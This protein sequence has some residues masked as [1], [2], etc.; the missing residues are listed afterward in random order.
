MSVTTA[1]APR[2]APP[3][4]LTPILLASLDAV[5]AAIAILAVVLALL[6]LGRAA[7]ASALR[8]PQTAASTPASV[9]ASP[10][11]AA[12]QAPAPPHAAPAVTYTVRAG[13]TLWSIS[14][15]H[16]GTGGD[17]PRLYIVNRVVIGSSPDHIEP[18]ETL[19]IPAISTGGTSP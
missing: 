3:P 5:V 12:A 2:H 7:P 1:Y 4:R 13:D 8:S 14:L 15:A 18:G 19:A 9:H 17:W 16:Y 6:A 10:A 11:P